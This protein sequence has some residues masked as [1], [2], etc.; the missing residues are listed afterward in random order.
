VVARLLPKEEVAGSNPVS[1]SSF[2]K[3]Q[4][5]HKQTP[6][7]KLRIQKCLIILIL[8]LTFNDLVS[9]ILFLGYNLGR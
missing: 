5:N 4:I 9:Q 3:S 1:R 2:Y 8:V 7:V 6:I